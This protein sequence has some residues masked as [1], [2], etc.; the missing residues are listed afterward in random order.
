[1][2][3]QFRTNKNFQRIDHGIVNWLAIVFGWYDFVRYFFFLFHFDD[4]CI[5][6][7]FAFFHF[8]NRKFF[9]EGL[10]A[11]KQRCIALY[12]LRCNQHHNKRV[13]NKIWKKTNIIW[14]VFIWA[15]NYHH[16]HQMHFLWYFNIILGLF[17]FFLQKNHFFLKTKKFQF[18]N[19]ICSTIHQVTRFSNTK[20]A[21][22]KLN[23]CLFVCTSICLMIVEREKCLGN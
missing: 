6:G 23:I 3:T 20:R 21:I 1:M 12:R 14:I 18:N 10:K 8:D 2:Q 11:Y 13:V 22:R 15:P 5:N 16:N 17:S 9:V 19:H 4:L 7:V